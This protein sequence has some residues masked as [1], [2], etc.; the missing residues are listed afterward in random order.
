MSCNLFDGDGSKSPHIQ[1]V[2]VID[3]QDAK[4]MTFGDSEYLMVTKYVVGIQQHWTSTN[5]MPFCRV[6]QISSKI[7]YKSCWPGQ[8]V[9]DIILHCQC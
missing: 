3:S 1:V 5:L 2:W 8:G 6:N 4:P 9:F 7:S